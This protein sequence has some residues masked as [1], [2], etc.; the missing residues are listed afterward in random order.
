MV[1]SEDVHAAYDY[2][3]SI[4]LF[5]VLGSHGF[6][7]FKHARIGCPWAGRPGLNCKVATLLPYRIQ[8]KDCSKCHEKKSALLNY[9]EIV[10]SYSPD[11]RSA[12]GISKTSRHR[13]DFHISSWDVHFMLVTQQHY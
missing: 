6:Y 13:T 1:R 5:H 2:I 4:F 7:L 8:T 12:R 10:I 3:F 11:N 9:M